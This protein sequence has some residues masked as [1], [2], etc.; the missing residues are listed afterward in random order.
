MF[1]KCS[2]D[3]SWSTAAQHLGAVDLGGEEGVGMWEK[4]SHRE[5]PPGAAYLVSQRKATG[6][7]VKIALFQMFF[8]DKNRGKDNT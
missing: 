1:A 4:G 8:F 5:A 7:L 6:Q 2:V 3:S